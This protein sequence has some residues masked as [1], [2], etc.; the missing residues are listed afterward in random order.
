[1]RKILLILFSAM[2]LVFSGCDIWE[3]REACPRILA[4]DCSLLEGKALYADIWIFGPQEGLMCRTRITEHEF[5]KRQIFEVQSG[6]YRCFVWA[7]LGDGTITADINTLSG[8]LY[9]AASKEVDPLFGYAKEVELYRDSALV[10]VQ[11]RK[12]FID[13]FITFTGLKADETAQVELISQYGGFCLD[14]APLPQQTVSKADG[15]SP[16][17]LRMTR[18]GN[19]EGIKLEVSCFRAG[20]QTV[21]SDFELGEYLEQNNYDLV[22]DIIKD[23]Y[24]TI[25]VAKLKAV[26]GT[27]P[28]ENVP[29]V[30]I[31]Y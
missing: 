9:K 18:P 7:N 15:T 30:N 12:M 28:F 2:P 26:I 5:Y 11:P 13:V 17:H 10:R 19:L 21:S 16:L 6:N 23:I 29:P 14:G 4:V 1:M 24:I 8:K 27:Q 31:N 20:N 25:D 22:S 3:D